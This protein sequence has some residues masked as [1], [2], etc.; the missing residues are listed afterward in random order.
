MAEDYANGL[1]KDASKVESYV[2][3]WHTSA[4]AID[5]KRLKIS[6]IS[7]AVSFIIT[8]ISYQLYMKSLNTK[9]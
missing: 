8:E 6:L 2:H 9:K 1:G 7:A 4:F 5:R 3:A